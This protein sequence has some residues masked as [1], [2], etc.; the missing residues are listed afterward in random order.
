MSLDGNRHRVRCASLHPNHDRHCDCF[1]RACGHH[2]VNLIQTN[3]SRCQ[4]G[5]KHCG[6]HS[7][8][9]DCGCT[10]RMGERIAAGGRAARR[11]AGHGSEAGAENLNHGRSRNRRIGGVDQMVAG[12]EN[13]ALSRSLRIQGENSRGVRRQSHRTVSPLCPFTVPLLDPDGTQWMIFVSAF[14][15]FS[16]TCLGVG[17]CDRSHPPPRAVINWTAATISD[18]WAVTSACWLA[19]SVVCAITTSR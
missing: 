13:G 1:G 9:S 11:L 12:V 8:D 17:S 19:S 14:P 15:G 10:G 7:T 5:K 2:Y 6:W 3:G 4:A 18:T 16:V